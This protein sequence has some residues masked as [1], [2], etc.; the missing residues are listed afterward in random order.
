[1][2]INAAIEKALSSTAALAEL[3]KLVYAL[4]A[5]GMNREAIYQAFL[6]YHNENMQREAW[7]AEEAKNNGDHPVDLTLDRI[8]GWCSL[9]RKFKI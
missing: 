4:A 6:Q 1:M 8:W 7:L 5:E 3:E 9:D 2:L